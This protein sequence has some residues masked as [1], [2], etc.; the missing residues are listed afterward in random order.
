[1]AVS[2][3]LAA[4]TDLTP[5][6]MRDVRATLEAYPGSAPL[7]LRWRDGR[8]AQTARFRSRSL[9]VA[10]SNAAINELRALLGDDRVKLVRGS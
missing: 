9:T 2:I 6:V 8:G 1:V 5:S 4:G 7:E 10:A 3:E